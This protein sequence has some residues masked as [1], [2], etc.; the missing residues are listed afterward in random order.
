MSTLS[1]HITAAE[2]PLVE[3]VTKKWSRE[4]YYKLDEQGWFLN[5]RVELF[6]GEIVV[7]SPQSFSHAWCVDVIT[8]RL[9]ELFGEDYWVRSQL[10]ITQEDRSEP[11]PDISVVRGSRDRYSD[12]P[13]S[14]VLIVEVSITTLQFDKT[15]KAN[16][17][18]SMGVPDYWVLDLENRQLLVHR[19]SVKDENAPFGHRYQQAQ[20]LPADGHVSPLEKPDAKLAVADMLPPKK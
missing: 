14:A 2:I 6:D 18:A 5:Q 12:H 4:E 7:V 19:D 11:E 15:K 9:K 16:L 3:P 1:H 20:M 8:Q 17:Y 10:P 13:Q